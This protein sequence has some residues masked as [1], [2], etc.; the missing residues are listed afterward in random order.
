MLCVYKKLHKNISKSNGKIKKSIFKLNLFH[1]PDQ[2]VSRK[3]TLHLSWYD[4]PITN[5]TVVVMP[6]YD[7][8]MYNRYSSHVS[9]TT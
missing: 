6:F 7:L 8:K 4:K 1:L 3:W 5:M 9:I 2:I